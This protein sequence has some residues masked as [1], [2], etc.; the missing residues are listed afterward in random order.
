MKGDEFI[1]DHVDVL[2]YDLNKISL[3]KGGSYMDSPKWLKIK[4]Q[5]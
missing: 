3:S 2:Y 5:Q 1:F 4:R